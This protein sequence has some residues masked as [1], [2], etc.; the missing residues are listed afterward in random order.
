MTM[1]G[2][3]I[4]DRALLEKVVEAFCGSYAY[5]NPDDD[6]ADKVNFVNA[7]VT[8]HIEDVV[9]SYERVIS[10]SRVDDIKLHSDF[11]LK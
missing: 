3:D 10:A 9:N 7:F 8:K 2:I 5:D 11:I 1:I 4:T 6:D